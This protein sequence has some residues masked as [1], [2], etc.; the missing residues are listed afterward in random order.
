MPARWPLPR[1]RCRS[2]A[3]PS[4]AAG[5]NL[6]TAAE[7]MESASSAAMRAVRSAKQALEGSVR[8][9]VA[10][11]FI[12]VLMRGLLPGLRDAHPALNVELDGTYHRVDL[13]KGE[14]DIA[15]RMARPD[16]SDLVAL[17]A[18]DVGWFVYAADAYLQAHGRPAGTRDLAR[19]ALVLY[20]ES[21]HGVAPL[22]WMEDHRDAATRVSR[23]DNLEIAC[24]AL[25]AGGG[26]GVLPCFI[27]DPVPGLQRVFPEC[28]AV[29]T[30]W[31]VYHEAARD[32]SRV[33]V[34]AEAL[35]AFFRGHEAMFAGRTG[36]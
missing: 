18:L 2:T 17:Q 25:A 26:I 12:P 10:P 3:P 1:V 34:V 6:L 9:S 24:Q 4:A 13:A 20:L 29:N 30:G 32:T 15:L 33:R 19:H 28:V 21:M 8:V 11:G 16:E 23:V 5:R 27:A 31:I 36:A 22:R 35:V 7:A 14:A